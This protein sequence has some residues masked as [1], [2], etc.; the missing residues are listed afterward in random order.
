MAG[1]GGLWAGDGQ[2]ES[3]ARTSSAAAA[4]VMTRVSERPSAL[5]MSELQGQKNAGW[6][7]GLQA[8][9]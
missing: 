6:M 4:V 5:A 3:G 2:Q 9:E 1:G 8:G 7:K